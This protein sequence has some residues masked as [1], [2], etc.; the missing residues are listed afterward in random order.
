M[1]ARVYSNNTPVMQGLSEYGWVR[2]GVLREAEP[3]GHGGRRD[4]VLFGML[5]AEHLAG[6][7]VEPFTMP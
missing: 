6:K 3:D 2:E 5:R 7:P 4:I 1:T